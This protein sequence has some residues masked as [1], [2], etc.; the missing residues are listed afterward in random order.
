MAKHADT[1]TEVFQES[2]KQYDVGISNYD[3]CAEYDCMVKTVEES[4][5]TPKRYTYEEYQRVFYPKR[6]K[7]EQERKLTPFELG[8]EIAD[9]T[10][11][12]LRKELENG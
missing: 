3:L 11:E 12:K 10:I 9:K 5:D 2:L 8:Q 7:R 1:C 6:W 4:Q